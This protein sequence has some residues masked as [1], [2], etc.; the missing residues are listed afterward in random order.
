LKN[1][2]DPTVSIA[3]IINYELPNAITMES[4][5]NLI[6]YWEQIKTDDG[7]KGWVDRLA[8]ANIQPFVIQGSGIFEQGLV[9]PDILDWLEFPGTSCEDLYTDKPK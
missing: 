5:T 6:V 3:D 1:V 8:N 7:T 9:D 4:I 2:N